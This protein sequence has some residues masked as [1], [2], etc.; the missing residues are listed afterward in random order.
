MLVVMRTPLLPCLTFAVATLATSLASARN[1]PPPAPNSVEGMALD[2]RAPELVRNVFLLERTEDL[3]VL[4]PKLDARWLVHTTKAVTDG[5]FLASSWGNYH[6]LLSKPGEAGVLELG[7]LRQPNWYTFAP[8]G[9]A[10]GW[11]A[12]DE[13]QGADL[14]FHGLVP[15]K[16]PP[17]AKETP[18]FVLGAARNGHVRFLALD[19]STYE[20]PASELAMGPGTAADWPKGVQHTIYVDSDGSYAKA[21]GAP[22]DRPWEPPPKRIVD[23]LQATRTALNACN[24]RVWRPAAPIYAA[25]DASNI[26][27]STKEARRQQVSDRYTAAAFATCRASFVAHAKSILAV[28]E[29]RKK[30]RTALYEANKARFGH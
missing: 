12:M 27:E 6:S 14:S 9:W 2:V 22:E 3:K 5:F 24:A 7:L 25:I 28:N 15:N 17:L 30:N 13:E 4:F 21:K 16:F 23:G 18:G 1:A 29:D 8:Y 11:E 19:G 26:S 10:M 20:V